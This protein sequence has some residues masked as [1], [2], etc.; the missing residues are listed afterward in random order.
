MS[1]RR[2]TG[3]REF[4]VASALALLGGAT[5]TI[6]GCGGGS[7]RTTGSSGP[8][9]VEG[10]I[11]GNHGHRAVITAAQLVAGG[12]VRLDVATGSAGHAHTVDL[13]A[14]DVVRIRTGN[15]VARESTEAELHRHMVSF[16]APATGPG[17][18]Y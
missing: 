13:S 10:S 9:D 2:E 15:A 12:A 18:S 1:R 14:D 16:V 8:V 11:A 6:T 4:T 7:S 17:S 3:R 5:I